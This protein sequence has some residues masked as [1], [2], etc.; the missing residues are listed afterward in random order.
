LGYEDSKD[1]KE[2]PRHITVELFAERSEVAMP[3]K[4]LLSE[5]Q[6]LDQEDIDS[7]RVVDE[8]LVAAFINA[9]ERERVRRLMV[10]AQERILVVYGKVCSAEDLIAVDLFGKSNPYVIVEA[11]S[12]TGDLIFMHRTRVLKN[13]LMP[14]WNETFMFQVPPDHDQPSIPMS[15][16][17]IRFSVYDSRSKSSVDAAL[18][19]DEDTLLGRCAV[20]LQFMRTCDY[21]QED[22]PLLGQ[23]GK[24]GGYVSRGGFKR[25]STLH[26]QVRVERRAARIVR[27]MFDSDCGWERVPRHVESRPN[28]IEDPMYNYTNFSQKDA[29]DN[30]PE[31][32]HA[33]EVLALKDSD[34]LLERSLEHKRR[35]KKTQGVQEATTGGWHRARAIMTRS[36]PSLERPARLEQRHEELEQQAEVKSLAQLEDK[37][38]YL[39]RPW[40]PHIKE[41]WKDALQKSQD[42]C[43]NFEHS[44]ASN[45]GVPASGKMHRITSLPELPYTRFGERY[46]ELTEDP[47]DEKTFARCKRLKQEAALSAT[48]E[49]FRSFADGALKRF[50]DKPPVREYQ[51]VGSAVY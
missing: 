19:D 7:G 29:T 17:S 39:R 48:S 10:S 15:L 43:Y 8:E 21:F 25:Y 18:L 6:E 49:S 22:I 40:L 16:S 27:K 45:M 33:Q 46:E 5:P 28:M 23:K 31:F 11:I 12:R 37:P 42:D 36:M 24:P 2:D 50:T 9:N 47:F 35:N 34:K 14:R 41:N 32:K 13:T 4:A 3:H 38:K 44:S 1:D 51:P 26:T 20:D 30:L